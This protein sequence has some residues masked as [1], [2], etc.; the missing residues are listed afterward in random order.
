MRRP[1]RVHLHA[2]ISTWKPKWHSYEST[3]LHSTAHFGGATSNSWMIWVNYKV[4]NLSLKWRES[5]RSVATQCVVCFLH[6]CFLSCPIWTVFK[7]GPTRVVLGRSSYTRKNEELLNEHRLIALSR[8][9]TLLTKQRVKPEKP[10]SFDCRG[11]VFLQTKDSRNNGSPHYL[12][13]AIF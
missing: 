12:H 11:R 10:V 13:L 7:Q 8:E 3:V 6:W 4:C 5:K 2:L 1:T 9:I